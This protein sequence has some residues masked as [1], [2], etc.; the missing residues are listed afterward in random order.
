LFSLVCLNYKLVSFLHYL[1]LNIHH[2]FST[3]VIYR[4]VWE[5]K[6]IILGQVVQT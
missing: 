1:M 3:N 2:H 4:A 5:I 6:T